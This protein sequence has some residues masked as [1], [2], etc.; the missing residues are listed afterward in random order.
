MLKKSAILVAMLA[1]QAGA[2]AAEQPRSG[3]LQPGMSYREVLERWGAPLFKQEMESKRE[4][5]WHYRNMQIVRFREGIVSGDEQA[6]TGAPEPGLDA[7]ADDA[8]VLREQHDQAAVKD[9]LNEIIQFSGGPEE[10]SPAGAENEEGRLLRML[11][12][13]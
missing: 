1:V 10:K 9:I 12:A 7:G 3:E 13:H 4:D 5:V 6:E 8:A 2:N 11:D